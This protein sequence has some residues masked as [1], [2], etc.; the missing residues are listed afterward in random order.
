[1]MEIER[2]ENGIPLLAAVTDDLRKLADKLGMDFT[3]Q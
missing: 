3:P 1:L 2:K